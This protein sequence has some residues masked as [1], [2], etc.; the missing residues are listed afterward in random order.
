MLV[1]VVVVLYALSLLIAR[2]EALGDL[3]PAPAAVVVAIG[4]VLAF[5]PPFAV[6]QWGL[7]L[8]LAVGGAICL[9]VAVLLLR[10]WPAPAAAGSLDA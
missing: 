3:L 7:S 8:W 1:V 5:V 4:F 2:W 6:M 9:G 10:R